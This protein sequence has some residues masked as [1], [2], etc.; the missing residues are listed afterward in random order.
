MRKESNWNGCRGCSGMPCITYSTRCGKIFR[1]KIIFLTLDQW[2]K[3]NQ[4]HVVGNRD[5]LFDTKN[6]PKIQMRKMT[7]WVL[8]RAFYIYIE[9]RLSSTRFACLDYP[10]I[11]GG[12]GG[13]LPYR[14]KSLKC[15]TYFTHLPHLMKKKNKNTFSIVLGRGKGM[16]AG[17]CLRLKDNN[18]LMCGFPGI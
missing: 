13:G 17:E 1:K 16:P 3:A 5:W 2:A 4:L 6:R 9:P 15:Q 7:R 18:W 12:L 14:R 11:Y 10:A 8:Q